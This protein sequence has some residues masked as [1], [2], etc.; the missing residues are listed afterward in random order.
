MY[1]SM[2][3]AMSLDPDPALSSL[4]HM[5]PLLLCVCCVCVVCVLCVCVVCVFCV[6]CVDREGIFGSVE[7]VIIALV[8]TDG[9]VKGYEVQLAIN[10]YHIWTSFLK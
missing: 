1:V 10:Y 7:H 5:P 9:C 4:S 6:F 8:L 2:T 3:N